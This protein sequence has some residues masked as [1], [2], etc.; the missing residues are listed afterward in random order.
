MLHQK[1]SGSHFAMLSKHVLNN[2]KWLPEALGLYRIIFDAAYGSL[3]VSLL[4]FSIVIPGLAA[5]EDETVLVECAINI[6][7]QRLTCYAAYDH[8][9]RQWWS[10]L[11]VDLRS[12]ATEGCLPTSTSS[13]LS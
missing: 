4:L 5:D 13:T 8:V 3:I 7:H 11:K 12:L 2:T 1:A 10:A 9:F 6:V